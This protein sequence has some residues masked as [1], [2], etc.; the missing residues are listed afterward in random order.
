MA[1]VKLALRAFQEVIDALPD[2]IARVRTASGLN[3]TAIELEFSLAIDK[4]GGLDTG[5]EASADAV[6]IATGAPVA[7]K[8]GFGSKWD[9]QGGVKV[10][11][12]FG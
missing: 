5:I 4:D 12:T 10:R 9:N 7:I 3:P 6:S 8:A 11:L 1:K 2:Q